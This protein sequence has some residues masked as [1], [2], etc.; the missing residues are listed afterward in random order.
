MA[1][2]IAVNLLTSLEPI[3]FNWTLS[4][5]GQAVDRHGARVFLLAGR[6]STADALIE[7]APWQSRAGKTWRW[8]VA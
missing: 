5:G 1:L 2:L 6:D 8:L 3:G 7:H 4:I